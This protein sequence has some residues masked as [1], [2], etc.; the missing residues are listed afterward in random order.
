MKDYQAAIEKL[1]SDAAEAALIRDLPTD[2]TKREMWPTSSKPCKPRRGQAS[3]SGG[4][5]SR[6]HGLAS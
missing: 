3:D 1:R 5:T 6:C 2:P 4:I